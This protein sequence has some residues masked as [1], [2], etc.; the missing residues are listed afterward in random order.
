MLWDFIF[1]EQFQQI[2]SFLEEITR[3]KVRVHIFFWVYT[4]PDKL[5]LVMLKKTF[6]FFEASFMQN[7]KLY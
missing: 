1:Q 6:F 7:I 2:W 4:Q 3:D 5:V